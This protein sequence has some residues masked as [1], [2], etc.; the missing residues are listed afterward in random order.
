MKR[1][2]SKY[3]VTAAK[4]DEAFIELLGK[5]DFEYITVKEICEKA[6][7][8]RSTFYLHYETI[9]DLLGE[10]MEYLDRQFFS[11]FTEDSKNFVSQIP[12]MKPEE[13]NFVNAHFLVPYLNYVK[14]NQ[15]VFQATIAHPE[16]LRANERYTL[17]YKHVIDPVMDKYNVPH[18][19]RIY[20]NT[21]F[22][23]GMIAVIREWVRQDCKTSPEEVADIIESLVIR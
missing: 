6:G 17:L 23:H 15:K 2:E 9:A 20:Y 11:Y 22:L 19:K 14:D 7:V 13:L 3:F 16:A 12:S 18:D 1:T 4:M 10:S 21:F 8:N 5:K